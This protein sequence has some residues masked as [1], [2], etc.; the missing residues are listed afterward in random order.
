MY[1]LI[2]ELHPKTLSCAVPAPVIAKGRIDA[3]DKFK[4]L[5]DAIDAAGEK[6]VQLHLKIKVMHDDVTRG[7]QTKVFPIGEIEFLL[8]Q[9]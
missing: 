8:I 1:D 4:R 5:S 2:H 3:G 9:R 6:G 7:A